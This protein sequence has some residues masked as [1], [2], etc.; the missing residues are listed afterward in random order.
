MASIAK[1]ESVYKETQSE[2]RSGRDRV[3][4]TLEK[5]WKNFQDAVE[6]VLVKKKFLEAA[7]E[8]AKIA[9][10]QYSTGL[11]S[12]NDWIIIENNLVDAKKNYLNAEANS[13][14]A[15]AYW[16]QAKGGTLSDG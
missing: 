5:N 7:K 12:F 14:E 11:I 2:E 3:I 8:R 4:L 6:W 9:N 1:S 15:K 13:L 16:I 10:A